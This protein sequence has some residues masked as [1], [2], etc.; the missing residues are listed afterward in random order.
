LPD[1]HQIT[2][3]GFH[4]SSIRVVDITEQQHLHELS[5]QIDRQGDMYAITV[6]PSQP[7]PRTLFAFTTPNRIQ[8]GNLIGNPA[9]TWHV[10]GQGAE[11]IILSHNNMLSAAK[12]L[13]QWREAQGLSVALIDIQDLYDAF[14][15]GAKD[16]QAIKAFLHDAKRH[17]QPAPRFALL[18][19]AA[20]YDPR[21]YLGYGP[22][23]WLPTNWIATELLE[24]ASDDGFV[25]FDHDSVADMPIGRL[26]ARS[27]AEAAAMVDK[28]LAHERTSGAWRQRA[29]VVTAAPGDFDFRTASE[30]LQQWLANHLTVDTLPLEQVTLAA[31]RQ[32]LVEGLSEGYGLA[33]YL[34]HGTTDRWD[35][36]GLLDTAAVRTLQNRNRLPIVLSMTCLSGFFQDP[37][38]ESL[39]EALLRSPTGGAAAVWASSGLTRP[40]GQVEMQRVVV[41]HLLGAGALPLGEAILKA[42]QAWPG[43]ARTWI[44]F[45]D[46]A[47]RFD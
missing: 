37:V 4:H 14:A 20:S 1:Q 28:L 47:M 36:G 25:D 16:P 43:D 42:K 8:P 38:T 13:Q 34:G 29:L 12:R 24:T 44:L 30:P 39:A 10:N 19:G 18:I 11:M 35:A 40:P 22:S 26:P 3:G 46:P 41:E 21:D 31:A 17:W 45:G 33:T 5:G 23:D 27:D 2:I 15:F 7:G 9:S 32:Q 6:A